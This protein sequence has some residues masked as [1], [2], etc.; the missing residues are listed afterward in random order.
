MFVYSYI[1]VGIT[2]YALDNFVNIEKAEKMKII[3]INLDTSIINDS[4]E[5]A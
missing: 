4:W 3:S 5:A 1:L 2:F